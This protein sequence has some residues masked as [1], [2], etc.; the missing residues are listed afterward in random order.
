MTISVG[1]ENK[2]QM[3][4]IIQCAKCGKE[5]LYKDSMAISVVV[6]NEY[7]KKKKT[8]LVCHALCHKDISDHVDEAIA[9]VIKEY[10]K[11]THDVLNFWDS[12]ENK[13]FE[14]GMKE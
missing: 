12:V 8:F 3:E 4:K 10:D 11:D 5:I 2:A 14:H 13:E 1:V 9:P 7:F 6:E